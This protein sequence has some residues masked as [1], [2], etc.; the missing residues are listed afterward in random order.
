MIIGSNGTPQDIIVTIKPI[1]GTINFPILVGP[2]EAGLFHILNLVFIRMNS[3]PFFPFFTRIS[4]ATS[5]VTIVT[6][7]AI[8][9]RVCPCRW[10]RML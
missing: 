2:I 7:G 10:Q 5:T 9:Y 4:I 1:P 8:K 6:A 3:D